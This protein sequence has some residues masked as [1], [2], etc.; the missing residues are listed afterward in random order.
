[1]QD[2]RTLCLRTYGDS[3]DEKEKVITE[4]ADVEPNAFALLYQID[5]D[6]NNDYYCLYNC[7]GTRP[8]IG[9]AT[10]TQS[11]TPQTRKSTISAVPL[12]DGKVMARTTEDTPEAV[13]SNWF[14]K[15]YEKVVAAGA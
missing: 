12:S 15:V 13:K 8:G 7:S 9:S 14:K 10:N 6:K 4:N 11:K 3:I 1:M 5:G 2:F